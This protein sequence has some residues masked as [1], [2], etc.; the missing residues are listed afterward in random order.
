VWQRAS[1]SGIVHRVL[2]VDD[3]VYV[4]RG[5]RGILD[6]LPDWEICGEAA[7]GKEAI[8]LNEELKPDILVMDISMP[9]MDGL[10][11]ARIIRR[12]HPKTRIILLTLHNSQE[13]IKTALRAG[14]SGYV[15]KSDAEE[16]LVAALHAVA[17]EETYISTKSR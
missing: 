4:R 17:K 10:E 3:H 11:A 7:N 5:V 2:I 16:E 12:T 14:A 8:R 15:L 9:E 13:L 6:Q 1:W